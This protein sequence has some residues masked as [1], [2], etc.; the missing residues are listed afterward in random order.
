[1]AAAPPADRTHMEATTTIDSPVAPT[2][3]PPVPE[4][5]R[6][7]RAVARAAGAQPTAGNVVRLLLDCRENFPAWLAAIEAAER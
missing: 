7:D 2:V 3:V 5:D 4:D 6:F 1:M